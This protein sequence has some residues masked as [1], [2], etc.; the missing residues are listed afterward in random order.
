M[1]YRHLILIL[2]CS[3]L[4]GCIAEDIVLKTSTDYTLMGVSDT[5]EVEQY[6]NTILKEQIIAPPDDIKSE[7][8]LKRFEAYRER[9]IAGTLT[10]ALHSKGYYDGAVIYK[11]SPEENKGAYQIEAGS[12]YTISAV[13]IKPTEFQKHLSALTIKDND[14]LVAAPVL[15]SQTEFYEAIQKD[16]CYFNLE[17]SHQVVLNRTEKT[18]KVIYDV[19]AGPKSVFDSVQFSGQETVDESYLRKLIPFKAGDCFRREKL[20]DLREAFLATGLFARAKIILPEA[21]IDGNKVPIEIELKER[22]HRTVRVGGIYYTDEGPGVLL[23]WEHRN[24]MGSAE[25]LE[26]QLQ[27]SQRQQRLSLDLTKPFFFRKD[28][29]LT[30]TSAFDSQN[31]D[32]FDELSL[33]AGASIKRSFGSALSG[34]TGAEVK[35]SRITDNN[36]KE[37][38]SFGLLSFPQALTFDNRNSKLNPKKG[39]FVK[40]VAE[41][42]VDVLGNSNPFFKTRVTTSTYFD[43]QKNTILALRASVGS[44][45]G[46]EIENVP[47][48]ERFYTG[49]GGSVRGFGYQE[50]GPFNNGDPTGGA[51][52]VEAST[53]LRFNITDTI[54]AAAF[55]DAGNVNETAAPSFSDLSVGAG[56]G[57]RYYT[58]FGPLRLDVATPL[59]NKEN[60]DSNY[61]I[62]ISIGQAF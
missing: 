28:Q 57:L 32:A 35:F 21:P 6:L 47:A 54:G 36:T 53:E 3:L 27:L 40:A 62:Y 20:D 45:N 55:V 10:K 11:D 58:S 51:S 31:S 25:K 41:P 18:G 38:E 13:S 60:T 5:P 30:L 23:G 16:E 39:W 43:L 59:T 14:I 34:S 1:I 44:I 7:D 4:V 56:V 9:L 37:E 26:A 24:F 15:K 46:T 61:Q 2:T 12:A 50:V 42:F 33:G 22:S 48:S 8:A 17:M 29:S 52:V 49:G 19:Q